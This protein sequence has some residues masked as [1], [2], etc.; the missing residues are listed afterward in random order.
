MK[1][2]DMNEEIRKPSRDLLKKCNYDL[3]MFVKEMRK[4]NEQINDRIEQARKTK[5]KKAA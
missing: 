1:K 2:T 3:D 5:H 4:E